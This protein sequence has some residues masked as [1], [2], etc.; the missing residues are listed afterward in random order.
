MRTANLIYL[1]TAQYGD[2]VATSG[3]LDTLLCLQ[4]T[5]Y[6][7]GQVGFE[8]FKCYTSIIFVKLLD[9]ATWEVIIC[10]MKSN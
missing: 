2:W 6:F 7:H 9:G 4:S 3:L 5:L 8:I 10:T 1:N